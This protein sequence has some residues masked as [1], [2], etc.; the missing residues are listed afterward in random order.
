MSRVVVPSPMLARTAPGS[1]GSRPRAQLG[2]QAAGLGLG[3][4]QQ[5]RDQRVRAEAAVADADRVLV[6]QPRG[7]RLGACGRRA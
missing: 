1:S 5:P 4:L 6:A 2:V 3:H 7:E